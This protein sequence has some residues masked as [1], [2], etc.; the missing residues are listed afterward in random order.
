[1]YILDQ[2][3]SIVMGLTQMVPLSFLS[4]LDSLQIPKHL[5]YIFAKLVAAEIMT[6]ER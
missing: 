4:A 3:N 5:S 2:I 6:D 1:M